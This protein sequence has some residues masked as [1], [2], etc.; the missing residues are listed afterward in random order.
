MWRFWLWQ[1]GAFAA[2]VA[3]AVLLACALAAV[4]RH[5]IGFWPWLADFS[6]AVTNA[7]RGNFGNS[8]V[9]GMPALSDVSR[10]FPATLQL[11]SAGAVIALLIGIPL[12][13]LFSA[14]RTLRMAAPLMQIVAAA[15]VFCAALALIWLAVHLLHWSAPPQAGAM[16]WKTLV[17]PD[18]WNASMI[19]FALPALTV[20]AA[21]AACV[22]L[23]LRRKATSVL[24]QPYRTGLRMMGLGAWEIDLRYVVPEVFSGLFNSLGE[25]ALGLLAAAAVAEWTFNRDGAA[26]LFLKS[27]SANDWNVAAL[28]L[29]IFAVTKFAADF[30]GLILAEFLVPA[31]DA[32]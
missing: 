23:A 17:T 28:V 12:G 25:I 6:D 9:S 8:S 10:V 14:S 21:G 32:E 4:A 7:L 11:L 27:V 18:Q 24:E 13:F 3:G 29:L 22:Q 2:N 5:P 31:G 1:V 16:S 26:V 20:G 30:I 19:G 15:P